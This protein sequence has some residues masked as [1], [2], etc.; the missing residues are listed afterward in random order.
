[1]NGLELLLLGHKLSAIGLAAMP[2]GHLASLPVS[3]RAILVDIF[4]NPGSAIKEITARTGYPQSL[5]SATV[6]KYKGMGLLVTG[7]DPADRRRT[8]VAPAPGELEEGWR[9]AEETSVDAALA[10][11]LPDVGESE[12]ARILAVLETLSGG[13][14][15]PR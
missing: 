12:L 7:T 8:I 9:E 1:M 3:A 15:K 13:L 6:A 2:H 5:V 10:A 14:L 4:D 11:A